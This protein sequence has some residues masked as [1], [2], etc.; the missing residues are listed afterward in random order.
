MNEFGYRVA[1]AL[2]L[3]RSHAGL[4]Q[5]KLAERMH[6]S[7]EV[8][9]KWEQCYSEPS[10]ADVMRWLTCC[11]VSAERF[12]D[13]CIHPGLLAHLE[14]DESDADKRQL[15][16]EAIDEATS[17]EVDALLYIRYGDHGSDHV[18]VL[19][20]ILANLHCP[21]DNRVSHCGTIISDYEVA[22]ARGTDPDPAGL[23]PK[24]SILKQ[25][26]SSGKAAAIADQQ[27]YSI[28]REV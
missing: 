16:H 6:I 9:A 8:A 23:Q 12:M 27:A 19:T 1:E 7:R 22:H 15:L 26:H 18:G 25:A 28:K 11:G 4:S 21:L 5:R 2:R 20:E 17:Y 14:D 3:A 13:A 24:M 10:L